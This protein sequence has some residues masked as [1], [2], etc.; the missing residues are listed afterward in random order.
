LTLGITISCQH[1]RDLYLLCRSTN[2][3]TLNRHYKKYC[4]ILADVIK[5]SK[6]RHYNKLLLSSTNKSKTSWHIINSLTNKKKSNHGIS[7]I[8]IDGK[9]CNDGLVIANAFSAYFSTVAEKI[10]SNSSMNSHSAP[11]FAYPIN[12]LTQVFSK[13]FPDINLNPTTAKEI[14]EIVKSL[15]SSQSCGYD[16]I[17]CKVLKCSLPCIISPLVY[18]CNMSLTNGMFPT[19]L[20][21]SQINPLFKKGNK[22]E[23]ANYRPISLL[24]SFSKIFEKVIFNRLRDYVNNYNILAQ[25]QYGFRNNLSM[26]AASFNLLINVLEAL[27][28]KSMVGGI[29][30]DLSKAFDCVNHTFLLSKLKFYGI[31][32]RAFKLL[33]SYLCDRYQRVF[34][35]NTDLGNCFSD[36]EKVFGSPSRI[37]LRP[38]AFFTLHQ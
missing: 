36:W 1:K 17:P 6:K 32:G 11:D 21:F 18:I 13:P 4:R 30:C 37:N 35:K 16:E 12:Y 22:S 7:S 29:F 27:N 28:N 9:T 24:T 34:L 20:K 15:R 23:M 31:M 19:Q 33:S 2:D 3:P 8:Q 38:A 25:E 10:P 26:E 5:S 14:T